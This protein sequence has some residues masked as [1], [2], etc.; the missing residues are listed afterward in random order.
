MRELPKKKWT[1]KTNKEMRKHSSKT[2][3]K[4]PPRTKTASLQKMIRPRKTSN[5]LKKPKSAILKSILTNRM[6]L[7]SSKLNWTYSIR[8]RIRSCTPSFTKTS[9][10][11]PLNNWKNSSKRRWSRWATATIRRTSTG[12][13]VSSTGTVWWSRFKGCSQRRDGTPRQSW[14]SGGKCLSRKRE[15]RRSIEEVVRSTSSS[16]IFTL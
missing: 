13:N 16:L 15:I 3:K 11:M 2:P 1:T 6:T 8:V 7:I 5:T 12:T 9:Y 10:R 4:K 14:S